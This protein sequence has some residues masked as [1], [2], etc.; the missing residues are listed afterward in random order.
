MRWFCVLVV[1]EFPSLDV[2]E[3]F[4]VYLLCKLVERAGERGGGGNGVGVIGLLI[5]SLLWNQIWSQITA[6][7]SKNF[8]ASS[9]EREEGTWI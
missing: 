1:C 5:S 2:E 8:G 4:F 3:K 9:K 6:A 7:K